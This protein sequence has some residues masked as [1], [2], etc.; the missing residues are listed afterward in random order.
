MALDW[1]TFCLSETFTEQMAIYG[2]GLTPRHW[3][4][5]R[6]NLPP[7]FQPEAGLVSDTTGLA[8]GEFLWPLIPTVQA[9]YTQLWQR[10]RTG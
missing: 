4:A 5:G 3:G 1:L 2:Q 8:N 9:Q 10:V 6:A 7:A